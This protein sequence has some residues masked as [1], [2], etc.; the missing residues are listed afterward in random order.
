M[1]RCAI[2]GS[3]TCEDLHNR[4]ICAFLRISHFLQ[5]F[6]CF[7]Y[8]YQFQMKLPQVWEL[9]ILHLCLWKK[10]ENLRYSFY[11]HQ[12]FVVQI[13]KKIKQLFK[14]DESYWSMSKYNA[15]LKINCQDQ[16][17]FEMRRAKSILTR[18]LGNRLDF[19]KFYPTS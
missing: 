11:I 3:A 17:W 8:Y 15:I 13:F 4:H 1:I 7:S 5:Q 10:I 19:I 16:M 14:V 6:R 2:S 18:V 9:I 12:M